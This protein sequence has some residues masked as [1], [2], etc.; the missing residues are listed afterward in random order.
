MNTS[1]FERLNEHSRL[2]LLGK[3]A[4]KEVLRVECGLLCPIHSPKPS[5]ID[6]ILEHKYGKEISNEKS[7]K[8]A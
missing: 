8:Q 4:L 5:L 2:Q 1:Y 7:S 6:A 3:E